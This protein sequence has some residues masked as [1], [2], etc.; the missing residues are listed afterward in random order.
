[1]TSNHMVNG[2]N[3]ILLIKTTSSIT[4]A[5][6]VLVITVC[7]LITVKQGFVAAKILKACLYANAMKAFMATNVNSL[8]L[9]SS[10][11]TMSPRIQLI[12]IIPRTTP[13]QMVMLIMI[14]TAFQMTTIL[15]TITM[16][17]P[18]YSIH[19]INL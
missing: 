18:T 10:A 5:L 9:S 8:Y 13:N 7:V 3:A 4:T 19:M 2:V 6:S 15:M 1:M 14:P 16:E 12:L 17:F 11:L